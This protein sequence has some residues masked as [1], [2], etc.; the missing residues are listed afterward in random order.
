M[1]KQV[2]YFRIYE[3]LRDYL[4]CFILINLTT[5]C[6][7][8]FYFLLLFLTKNLTWIWHSLC[9][10]TLHTPTPQT[11]CTL[12]YCV[13]L[14]IAINTLGMLMLSIF[15]WMLCTWLLSILNSYLCLMEL[16]AKNWLNLQIFMQ[17]I[18]TSQNIMVLMVCHP[19]TIQTEY[20]IVGQIWTHNDII[21]Y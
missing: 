7:V 9:T 11:L 3:K 8:M 14:K 17:I 10:L 16:S 5:C 1:Y 4:F 15:T 21:R 18:G 12:C 2:F 19:W 13:I 20:H 6:N